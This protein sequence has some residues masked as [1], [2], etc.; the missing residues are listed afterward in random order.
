MDKYGFKDSFMVSLGVAL[1]FFP[2]W[3]LIASLQMGLLKYA[4][5]VLVGE[6]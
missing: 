4:L 6:A 1:V 2:T 3:L 5:R